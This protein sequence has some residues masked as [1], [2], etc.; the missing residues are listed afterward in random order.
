MHE[1]Q[2]TEGLNLTNDLCKTRIELDT[3]K[4]KVKLAVQTFCLSVADAIALCG[5]K[6]L[7]KIKGSEAM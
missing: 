7:T 1:L 4:M 6:E 3:Q 5:K 2:E